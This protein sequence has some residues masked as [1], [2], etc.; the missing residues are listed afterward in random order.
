MID[1][2]RILLQLP[3]ASHRVTAA[4]PEGTAPATR[5]ARPDSLRKMISPHSARPALA[6][7]PVLLALVSLC[8]LTQ[9]RGAAGDVDLS[10]DPGSGINGAI[11]A[12]AVQVDGKILVGGS[13]AGAENEKYISG[14]V[15][16]NADGSFDRSFRAGGGHYGILSPPQE[17]ADLSR[18]DPWAPTGYPVID[19]VGRRLVTVAIDVGRKFFRLQLQ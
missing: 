11:H 8:L 13:Y 7:R 1:L 15:R 12:I 4:P 9:A 10:F 17:A 6:A 19:T 3:A 2:S 14:P 16:F 18:P 5:I